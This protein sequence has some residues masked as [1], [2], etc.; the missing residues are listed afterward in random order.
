MSDEKTTTTPRKRRSAVEMKQALQEQIRA[1][2]ERERAEV[3][4][5][6]CD[7]YDTLREASSLDAARPHHA[8]LAGVL[9]ALDPLTKVPK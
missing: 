4:R 2:E 5:L 6:V 8:V 1:L 7:A 3:L 9:K